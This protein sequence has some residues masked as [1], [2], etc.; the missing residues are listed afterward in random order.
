VVL[1]S[2]GMP[3]C[4]QASAAAAAAGFAGAA[5]PAALAAAAALTAASAACPPGAGGYGTLPI[6][7]VATHVCHAYSAAAICQSF[8]MTSIAIAQARCLAGNTDT[9]LINLALYL[10]GSRPPTAGQVRMATEVF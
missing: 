1:L 3:A 10:A 6:V 2:Q 7:S 4:V 9:G 8:K 5:L